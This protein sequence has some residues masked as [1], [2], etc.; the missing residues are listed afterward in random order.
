MANLTVL[1]TKPES[2]AEAFL[3]EFKS[4]HLPIAAR[5]P[6]MASHTTTVFSGTPRGTEAPY[7]LMF[8]AT[9]D[10]PEAMKAAMGDPSIMEASKHAMGLTQKYGIKAEMLIGDEA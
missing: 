5:F 7:Y 1:Y 8:V 3:E 9:W 2:D 6:K 10:S 4:D